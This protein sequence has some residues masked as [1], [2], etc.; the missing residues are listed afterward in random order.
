MLSPWVHWGK[1]IWALS[2]KVAVHKPGSQFPPGTESAGILI[3]DFSAFKIKAIVQATQSRAFCYNSLSKLIHVL[4][5]RGFTSWEPRCCTGMSP[6]QAQM[7]AHPTR[8]PCPAPHSSRTCSREMI[9]ASYDF[10]PL[11][12]FSHQPSSRE[13]LLRFAE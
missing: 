5:M 8:K 7:W 9:N 2:K 11:P 1:V 6:S 4:Q 10:T 12:G 3:S 13:A